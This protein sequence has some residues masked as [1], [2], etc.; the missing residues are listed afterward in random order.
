MIKFLHGASI[1]NDAK[2]LIGNH[3][4]A[5]IAV[6]YWGRG[7]FALLGITGD[8]PVR[9]LCDVMSAGCNPYEIEKALKPPLSGSVKVK[10]LPRLHSKV[11]LADKAVLVGSA[12]AS[13]N[14]LGQQGSANIEAATMTNDAKVISAAK[15][16]FDSK[17][18]KEAVTVTPSLLVQAKKV[19]RPPITGTFLE[20]LIRNPA[21]FGDKV[22][23]WF[24]NDAAS[25]NAI[26]AFDRIAA[27]HYSKEEQKSWASG[28]EPFYETGLPKAQAP[29]QP[30]DYLVNCAYSN[31]P[32]SIVKEPGVLK[33]AS[34][35]SIL[36]T[37][38]DIKRIEGLPFPAIQRKVLCRA[39]K[40]YVQLQQAN[41]ESEEFEQY[42]NDL[43]PVFVRLIEEEFKS[44][45]Q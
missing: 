21:L 25:E 34:G 8:K 30:G 23:F 32:V 44:I 39:A 19:K 42:A 24:V 9:I 4:S 28:E 17:W 36:L 27:N 45:A 7:A 2:S 20:E 14:G 3:E 11:F 29:Y 37:I 6:A 35:N 18:Y 1:L 33:I 5:D 41:G 43:H 10:Y 13:T 15:E 16:W 31:A 26:K 38:E 22:I 12:N 40:R